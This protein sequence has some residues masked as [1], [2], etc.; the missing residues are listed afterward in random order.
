MVNAA[1][2]AAQKDSGVRAKWVELPTCTG[3]A[4]ETPLERGL[5][6]AAKATCKTEKTTVMNAAQQKDA[7]GGQVYDPVIHESEVID[8]D[9]EHQVT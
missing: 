1:N 7:H 2:A 3:A 8:N 5:A 6:N 4:D 9:Y